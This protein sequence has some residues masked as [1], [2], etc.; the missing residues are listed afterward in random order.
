MNLSNDNPLA[1]E[2]S[3]IKKIEKEIDSLKDTEL[4]EYSMAD[5][6]KPFVDLIPSLTDIIVP[7]VAPVHLSADPSNA[8][9]SITD[10]K[11]AEE[12]AKEEE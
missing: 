3:R 11:F 12:I 5:H 10:S 9:D 7:S 8:F 6:T 1:E 4:L 2:E